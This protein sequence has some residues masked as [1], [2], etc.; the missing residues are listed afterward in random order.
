LQKGTI[1]R[2]HRSW[3][4]GFNIKEERNGRTRW[5]WHVKRLAPF[6]DK[7]RSAGSVK[8]IAAEILSP[9]NVQQ[10]G[11]AEPTVTV[12]DFVEHTYLPFV[13]SSLRP[14]TVS[15]YE[16]LYDRLK[17][18][19]GTTEMREFDVPAADRV[20]AAVTKR[21]LAHTTHRNLRNFL[22]GVFRY[23]LRLGVIRHGNPIRDCV[24]PKGKPK[25]KTPAYSIE[26]IQGAL[27][28]LPEPARTA[29]L[30]A[31]LTGL[32]HA[33]LRAIRYSDIRDGELYVQR[34]AW[35]THVNDT[36][37]LTSHAPVPL[38]PVVARAIEALRKTAHCDY[39]FAGRTGKPLVLANTVRKVI[40]PALEKAGLK[41]EGWH[42]LRRGLASN[43]HA[44]GVD[45]KTIQAILR[46]AELSTTMDIY[47]KTDMAASQKAMKRLE[48][49][50]GK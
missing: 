19:L 37:T 36:K 20:L 35:N 4:V 11:K 31:A 8:H 16:S 22:S 18:F 28:V 34:S 30:V 15:V 38:L 49:A 33:E 27:A 14:A 39:V 6:S 32:R 40:I 10:P 12:C 42:G 24:V 13:R 21:P 41:W 23:A 3:Y 25:Q 7:Y 1:F 50:F 47:V 29:V 9:L 44:L 46:H 48:K 17:P 26:F 43:L 45:G 2:K 5:R